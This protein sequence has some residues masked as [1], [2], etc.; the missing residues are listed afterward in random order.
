M[1]FA[2]EAGWLKCLCSDAVVR[3]FVNEGLDITGAPFSAECDLHS[4][5]LLEAPKFKRIVLDIV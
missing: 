1:D 3:G 2:S 4:D 5:S